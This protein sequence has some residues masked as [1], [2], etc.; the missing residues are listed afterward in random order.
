MR[1]VATIDRASLAR[2]D[3]VVQGLARAGMTVDQILSA[4]GIVTGKVD[5][6][7]LGALVRVASAGPDA[8]FQVPPDL[9]R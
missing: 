4:T 9:S 6:N 1:T 5:N 2:I 8:D 7:A 3:Q